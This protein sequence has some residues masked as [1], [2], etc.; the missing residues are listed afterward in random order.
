MEK[1]LTKEAKEAQQK[2]LE[3]FKKIIKKEDK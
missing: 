2:Q 1:E 3:A